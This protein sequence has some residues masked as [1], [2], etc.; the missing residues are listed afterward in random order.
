[1]EQ[2]LQVGIISSTH[3]IRGEVKVFPTTD[4][5]ARFKVLKNVILDTGKEQIPMEIQGVKFFKQFV[6]VKFKGIDNINDIEKYKGKSL[7]V[8]RE[9]A[10]PLE[11][12]EYYIADLIGM[13][14]FTE[15]GEFG[16]L[17]D[18]IETGANEVYVVDSKEHGEVLI[19]A[20]HDCILDVNVEEQTMKVHLLDGLI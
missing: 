7:L 17:K 2:Y 6:I 1:M 19:P 4:D 10:S 13:T 20:I 9:N 12:D 18:V 16:M 8:T 14:V 5:P 11:E 3:G 15:D